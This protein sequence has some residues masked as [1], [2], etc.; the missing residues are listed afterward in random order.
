MSASNEIP[1][2]AFVPAENQKSAQHESI[3]E[4]GSL[5][6]EQASKTPENAPVVSQVPAMPLPPIQLPGMAVQPMTTPLQNDVTSTTS[7]VTSSIIEDSDLIEKEWVNKAKSIVDAN[8][9]D[10]YKQSEE[11]TGVKA[12]YMKK[13][14]NKNIKLK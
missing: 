7:S 8:R 6:Q 5:V 11:L 12:D 14:Y 13:R 4:T 10:P 9:E 3:N 2:Q 1:G